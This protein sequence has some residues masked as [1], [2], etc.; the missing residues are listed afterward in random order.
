MKQ[1]ILILFTGCTCLLSL[2]QTRQLKG[3][4]KDDSGTPLQGVSVVPK[5]SRQG[6]QT[7]KEG[8]FLL[9]VTG[10]G[11]VT[12]SFSY[13]GHKSVSL[14][15]DG[16][17]PLEVQME[18]IQATLEDVVVVG[19][20][21][22]RRKD[23]LASV[24]SVS[25]K[26]LKD[27]PINSAAEALNGRLAGVTATTAEGSPDAEVRIRIR[28][29]ISI[30]GDNS[31]LYIIDGVQMENALSFISPQ[32]ILYIDVLKDAAATSIYGA[33]GTNGVIVITT[34]SGRAGKLKVNYNA[35]TGIKTLSKKLSVLDPYDF[36]LYQSERS[37]GSSTD[38]INFTN[39]Y[40][41]TW[42]TLSVYKSV[43]RIDWQEE[44]FGR[45]GIATTHN[46]SLSGGTKDFTY[47]L[48]YTY[49]NEK[50][51]V[52]NS[53]Y[54]RH[55][56]NFKTDYTITKDLKIGSSV[57][58]TNQD[59]LG[60]GVS[61]DKGSAYNKLRN[62]IKYRPFLS[63]GQDIDDADPLADPNVGNGLN[64]TNPILLA[65]AEYRNRLSNTYNVTVN[66][67]Y[68]ILKGLTFK[69]TFGYT[70][71]E[72]RDLQYYDTIAPYAIIQGGAKPIARL[73]TV[74]QKT[75]TNSNVLSYALKNWKGK[76]DVD[77]LIGE[78]TYDLKTSSY[79]NLFG[80]YPSFTTHQTAFKQTSLGIPFTGYPKY[81]QSRYTNLSFFGSLRYSFQDKYLFSFNV[82]RDGASKFAPGRR[83]GT[84]PSASFAWR[85]KNEKFMEPVSFISDLKFRVGWGKVGNNRIADYLYL[86]TFR[87]DG[88]YYYGINNN[89][90]LAYYSGGLVNENLKWEA[91][92][93]RNV[94]MDI[95][96]FNRRVDLSVDYYNNR[97]SD[98]L[99][100]VPVAS[101]FGYSTQIQNI[102]KTSNKGWEFQLNTVI[103]HKSNGLNWNANFNISFN[104]N[105]VVAL[106]V[107]QESFFAAPSWG[108]SGQPADYIVKIGSPVGAMWGLVTDGFYTLDDFDYDPATSRYTL[109]TGV[110]N[111]AS[112]IG[113][114]QPGSIKFKDLNGDGLVNIANDSKIIGNPTPTF[115][116][117][118][119]QQFSYKRW[120]ASLFVNFSYG[121]DVYNANKIELTNA[122]SNNSNM[123][124][125][126]SGRW[127][128][129]TPSG[130]T[131]QWVSGNNVYG[132]PKDQLAALNAQAKIWMP[133]RS[134]GAFYPHSWAIEDG[135]FL[136]INNVSVGYTIPSQNV[137]GLKMSQI[138][139]YLTA[140]NLA[141]LTNYSGYDPEVSVRNNPL[142]PGLD[143]SAYPKSRS[144]IFGVNASF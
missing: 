104:K 13:V 130:A 122:Y 65:D 69:S 141:I 79:A 143:Y 49:N 117:G 31:P 93:N 5:G 55:I 109:K 47:T 99:L 98:L 134:A 123:L 138:R 27:I 80:R 74:I 73:D 8:N 144:F 107:N 113:V 1:F 106:G 89:A 51:I 39:N 95:S 33:R 43:P 82:R 86:T 140:N 37:R 131:A 133:L 32:D 50:A 12:L 11:S 71:S 35:F 24:S 36:V 94:G 135:S 132:L 3:T 45:T 59:V 129:V 9:D 139:F 53:S 102:G 137:A 38:S 20:Q 118:L 68:K 58:F 57:R 34:K 19:Y 61:D 121:N 128:V 124:G 101:T 30:T 15:T 66:G 87:N 56:L 114:V 126:M 142:T 103:L 46:L 105:K 10:S 100:N 44:T 2:A 54:R 75:L 84:F 48:G 136:R 127:K 72:R 60:A 17:L 85:L 26:D 28:G 62:A 42:D 41:H 16:K 115:T 97:S 83:W 110:V 76:H 111:N 120:D 40:G 21:T 67:S 70:E 108:V 22:L 88:T 25:A 90:I 116:G 23:L 77:V 96:L 64:L 63:S 119:Q 112:I 29:G 125:I 78:E 14:V 6:T 18:K 92:E 52:L 81:T 4:V 7:D 91:T